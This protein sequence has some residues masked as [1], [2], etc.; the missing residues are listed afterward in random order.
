[1]KP[2]E[3]PKKPRGTAGQA[4]LRGVCGA[5]KKSGGKCQLMSGFGTVHPGIGRCK[6]HGGSVP[7]QVKAAATEE[8]RILLGKPVEI[9][10][11][12]ALIK[13]IHIRAG[14]V[15]WLSHKMAELDKKDWIEDT[16]VGKQLHLYARERRA[17]LN[18]L[19][20]YSQ[21]AVSLGIAERAVK[22]AEQYAHKI[23]KLIDGILGELNL[24]N[25]QRAM[26]PTIVRR[27]LIL[28]EGGQADEHPVVDQKA[29]KAAS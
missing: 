28:I 12:E 24:T 29:L 22:L 16:L 18:D 21:M 4:N 1:L 25:E 15:E 5:K 2:Y 9:N 8:Y 17:A 23:A 20:R 13:C 19:A 26:V 6:Y 11:L 14:E 3:R 27:Q 7:N 10:P